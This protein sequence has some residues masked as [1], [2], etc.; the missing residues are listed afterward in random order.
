MNKTWRAVSLVLG[1]VMFIG[2]ALVTNLFERGDLP[3]QVSGALLQSVI[4]AVMTYFLLSGQTAQEELKERQVKV[5]EKKQEVYHHFIEVLMGVVRKGEVRV[6]V[7]R[8][9][10]LANESAELQDLVEQLGVLQMHAGAERVREISGCVARLIEGLNTWGA[11]AAG[12]VARDLPKFYGGVSEEVFRIVNILKAD[13]YGRSDVAIG[14]AEMQDIFRECGLAVERP[15][16]DRVA[17]Q[18]YFWDELQQQLMVRGYAVA[19]TNLS[20]DV[21]EYYAR[22]RN[23]HRH[24]GFEFEVY[25]LKGTGEKVLF[26]VEVENHFYYGFA[27][28]TPGAER[29]PAVQGLLKGMSKHFYQESDKWFGAKLPDKESLDFWKLDS[30]GFDALANA[31]SRE[32]Y[33]AAIADEMDGYIKW[34]REEAE[35]AGV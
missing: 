24:F 1:F 20:G 8:E 2:I 19:R 27:K 9:A 32:E 31:E 33:V 16:L 25:E 35:R 11:S 23:R 15:G 4:T 3:V 28:G 34:F 29:H 18:C 5:F 6:G 13:L 12:G 21:K 10:R 7:E 14:A 30:A 17:A 26:R 22:A